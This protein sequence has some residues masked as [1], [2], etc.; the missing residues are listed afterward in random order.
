MLPPD[1]SGETMADSSYFREKAAQAFRL[2][3]DSTDPM[4]IVSLTELAAEYT[5]RAKAIDALALGQDP[6]R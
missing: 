2:A 6:Q 4:L 1:P 5:E 3:S